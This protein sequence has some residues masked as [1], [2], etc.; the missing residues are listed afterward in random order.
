MSAVGSSGDKS[1]KRSICRVCRAR[2]AGQYVSTMW[3]RWL[4]KSL[5]IVHMPE[6]LWNIHQ[7]QVQRTA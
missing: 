5:D 3:P 7:L 4:K 1:T 2:I 6:W